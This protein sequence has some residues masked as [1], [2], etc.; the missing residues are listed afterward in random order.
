MNLLPKMP[1]PDVYELEYLYWPWGQLLELAKNL[2]IKEAPEQGNVHDYMCGTG[3]LLH[4]IA[5]ERPDLN[6]SGSTLEPFSYVEY[7]NLR[8]P[9]SNVLFQDAFAYSPHNKLD[10]I[11]CTA[12]I[13]HL[14]RNQQSLFVQKV[15][16]ELRPG[17]LFLVGEE[18]IR[19][20]SN[21]LERRISAC[22]MATALTNYA[23]EM[24]APDSVIESAIDLFL[25]DVLE[26]GEYKLSLS[27]LLEMLTPFF[28][29]NEIRRIWP[30]TSGVGYGD[31][32]LE[33][34]LKK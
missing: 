30:T 1:S 18:V 14:P 23:I 19:Q 31:I 16:R 28:E 8:N 17:G 3:Y 5:I 26:R 7:A 22:E 21:E 12:G 11:V 24:E 32:L 10:V 13:H 2:I 20:F 25:N 33:C 27:M 4:K 34:R 9:E 15:A 29:V 6:L